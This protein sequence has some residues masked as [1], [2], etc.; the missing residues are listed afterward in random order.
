MPVAQL[1]LVRHGQS[2][3]N[4]KNK[5]TGWQ[6]PPLTACGRAE[7]KRV[8]HQLLSADITFDIAYTSYLQRAI[9]TSWI[10]RR[11]MQL[12]WLPTI[13]DWRLNERHYGALQGLDKA[14]TQKKYGAQQVH[15]WRRHPQTR[16]PAGKKAQCPDH[17]YDGVAVPQGENL[18]DTAKRVDACYQQHLLP[19]LKKQKR[20]LVVAHGNSIRALIM[21]LENTNAEDIVKIEIPTGGA[22]IYDT[23]TRGIPCAAHKII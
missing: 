11:Q 3:W 9:E 5:F 23:D 17:R 18:F 1:V 10:I 21:R 7:A 13:T 16:P 8:S 14:Q 15:D 6:D 19:L 4:K 2:T 20:L 22:V 12:L